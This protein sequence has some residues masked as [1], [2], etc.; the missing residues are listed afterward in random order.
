MRHYSSGVPED[1]DAIPLRELAVRI[2]EALATVSEVEEEGIPALFAQATGVSV[3][4]SRRRLFTKFIW[5]AKARGFI[6][7]TTPDSGVFK[8]ASSEVSENED[9]GHETFG[10]ICEIVELVDPEK[11][12]SFKELA[13]T[14][15]EILVDRGCRDRRLVRSTVGSAIWASGRRAR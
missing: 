6:D 8:R 4:R 3:P 13:D 10:A 9:F 11:S 2:A 5:S 1:F 15:C 7:E 14:V 12:A